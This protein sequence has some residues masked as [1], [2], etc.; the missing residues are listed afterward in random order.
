MTTNTLTTINTLYAGSPL[1]QFGTD[2]DSIG[3]FE[4]SVTDLFITFPFLN[5]LISFIGLS[6]I[7]SIGN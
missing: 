3:I 1:D 6:E 7:D 2:T 4:N 5:D